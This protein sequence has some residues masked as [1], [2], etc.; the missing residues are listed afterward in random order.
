MVTSAHLAS[1]WFITLYSNMFE[2]DFLLTIWDLFFARGWS[3][4]FAVGLEMMARLEAF[5]L[6]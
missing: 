2:T 3:A 6:N 4:I 5:L 1:G